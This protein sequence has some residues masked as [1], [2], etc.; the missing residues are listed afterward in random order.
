[1]HVSGQLI[2]I[3]PV[4]GDYRHFR[5]KKE[6]FVPFGGIIDISDQKNKDY[7]RLGGFSTFQAKRIRISPVWGDIACFRPKEEG[8]VPFVR[9]FDISGQK[10]KD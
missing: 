2:K 7:S 5:P 8:F 9:I 4:Y 10:N 6:G 3:Y 1:L